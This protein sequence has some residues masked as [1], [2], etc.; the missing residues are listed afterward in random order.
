[1]TRCMERAVR[2]SDRS[3]CRNA[4]KCPRACPRSVQSRR[5]PQYCQVL[6]GAKSVTESHPVAIPLRLECCVVHLAS[7]AIQSTR[8]P[9]PLALL[10]ALKRLRGD[11]ST[12]ASSEQIR[13]LRAIERRR[14]RSAHALSAL[15]DE[16]LF[17]T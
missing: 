12:A 11:F 17:L 9:G 16:L 2:G 4:S 7:V 6:W 13:L 10:R 1:M 5:P 8:Q 3:G 15:H 14:L